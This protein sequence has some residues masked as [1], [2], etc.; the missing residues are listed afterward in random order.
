MHKINMH[1]T[2]WFKKAAVAVGAL[3]LVGLA[4]PAVAAGPIQIDVGA[5]T[6]P[7]VHNWTA[8]SKG[9]ITFRVHHGAAVVNMGCNT[10][11]AAGTI[12]AG[13]D[14]DGLNVGTIASSV[15]GNWPTTPCLGPAGLNMTVTQLAGWSLNLDLNPKPTNPLAD[16][17]SGHVGGV[18]AR[19]VSKIPGV[20]SFDVTGTADAIF[21]EHKLKSAGPPAVYAQALEVNETSGNLVV[22]NVSGCLGAIANG[23]P[24]DFIGEFNI[25][26]PDGLIN[27]KP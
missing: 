15:W 4:N 8:V 3:T 1:R 26:S 25:T 7:S 17:I 22:S 11:S 21:D 19:V 14:A 2:K 13:P 24:A 18:T 10:A 20:C 27:V 12:N 23:D 5:N 16:R 9:A 6:G